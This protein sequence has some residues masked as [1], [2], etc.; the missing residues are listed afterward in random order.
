MEIKQIKTSKQ[1]AKESLETDSPL[2]TEKHLPRSSVE[3][4]PDE[5]S[6]SLGQTLGVN[7]PA[8]MDEKEASTASIPEPQ[9]PDSLDPGDEPVEAI[10]VEKMISEDNLLIGYIQGESVIGV[11][12]PVI[13]PLTDEHR[14]LGYII[15]RK[16]PSIG[17]ITKSL[18]SAKYSFSQNI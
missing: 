2:N 6:Q 4:I 11:F 7:D 16:G 15:R 8:L 10:P 1:L 3:E 18:H 9:A 12:E 14:E 13:A 5:E 17:R